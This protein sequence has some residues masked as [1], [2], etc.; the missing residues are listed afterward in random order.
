MTPSS[1]FELAQKIRSG[2]I[3]DVNIVMNRF[4]KKRLRRTIDELSGIFPSRSVIL[5]KAFLAHK[6]QNYELS[7]PVFLAQADGIC[8]ELSGHHL[9]SNSRKRPP[10][11]RFIEKLTPDSHIAALLEPLRQTMPISES[12]ETRLDPLSLNRHGIL[13]GVDVNY[14]TET[15]SFKAM[16]LLS[17]VSSVLSLERSL[18]HPGKKQRDLS[19]RP[20]SKSCDGD[21]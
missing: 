1:S 6:K 21:P 11:K 13:H 14:A 8:Q 5:N 7:I 10:I 9:F 3:K 4:Y 19:L 15:N 2:N 20:R 17:Y 18:D 16:S 12:T